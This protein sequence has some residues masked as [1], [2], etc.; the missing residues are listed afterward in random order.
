MSV[1]S[2]IKNG[3]PCWRVR[4]VR[5]TRGFKA[6]RF[7]DRRHHTKREAKA[8]E[9]Q[10]IADFENGREEGGENSQEHNKSSEE[11]RAMPTFAEFVP[12]YEAVLDPGK[13]DYGN[14]RQILRA[15]LVPFFG[16]SC[17]DEIGAEQIEQYRASKRK[18]Q[19]EIASSYRSLHRKEKAKSDRRKGGRLKP[20]TINNTL[21]VLR[22]VL[23]KAQEWG[24]IDSIPVIKLE[25]VP[26][27]D[28]PALTPEEVER[29]REVLAPELELVALL[30]VRAG[31][32]EGEI[33]E[34][35][36]KD[37]DLEGGKLRLSRQL[38]RNRST[39]EDE[40][41]ELK[42]KRPRT[43]PI[44]WDLEVALRA[45]KGKPGE[46]VC[47][48]PDGGHLSVHAI[49]DGLRD[50][51]RDAGLGDRVTPHLLRH[52]FATTAVLRG[53]PINVLQRWLGHADI[54]TT[55]R[56]LHAAPD[57]GAEFIDRVAPARGLRVIESRAECD[58]GQFGA[59][60]GATRRGRRSKSGS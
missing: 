9:R 30:A 23:R 47:P 32:R 18:P 36:W 24:E 41:A 27:C 25:H 19:G 26:D 55:Q 17:L 57:E 29:V 6:E 14:K 59:T 49:Y 58:R 34:V 15:H 60:K 12:R 22:R 54:T 44:S 7:L 39:G 37:V 31:L 28:P 42:G 3:R 51:G 38:R 2:V 43:V 1:S 56:Y 45:A 5:K 21:T 20:K 48:A 52:T 46:L 8:L 4:V 13:N 35:R 11:A 50:A 40:I 16:G 33:R 53:V 10:I